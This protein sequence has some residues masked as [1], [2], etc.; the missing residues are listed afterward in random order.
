MISETSSNSKSVK[1]RR[2][3]LEFPA[4][5]EH[6]LCNDSIELVPPSSPALAP[7]VAPPS[8]PNAHPHTSAVPVAATSPDGKSLAPDGPTP[9]PSFSQVPP[10]TTNG[11]LKPLASFLDQFLETARTATKLEK[12]GK[13]APRKPRMKTIAGNAPQPQ[14][15][16]TMKSFFRNAV[17][18]PYSSGCPISSAFP[19]PF[20]QDPVAMPSSPFHFT[21]STTTHVSSNATIHRVGERRT[22][23]QVLLPSTPQT[24]S[25]PFALTSRD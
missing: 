1:S 23:Y 20:S 17:R 6:T 13:K 3:P 7:S 22:S 14:P 5:T 2:A 16:S 10:R 8:T 9:A 21:P 25:Q 12:N 4:L 15:I 19:S 11:P 24:P 18:I